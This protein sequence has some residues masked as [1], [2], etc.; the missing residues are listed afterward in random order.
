M[1]RGGITGHFGPK[2]RPGSTRGEPPAAHRP[3]TRYG[4]WS[5]LA[6]TA[7]FRTFSFAFRV[8]RTVSHGPGAVNDNAC[9]VLTPQRRQEIGRD[10]LH[11]R[12]LFLVRRFHQE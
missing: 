4:P 8:R 10:A 7:G 6:V 12:E 1:V 3:G 5:C 11:H 9:C 2:W